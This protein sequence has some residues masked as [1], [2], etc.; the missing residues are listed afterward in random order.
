MMILHPLEGK[1][2][3]GGCPDNDLVRCVSEPTLVHGSPVSGRDQSV[4]AI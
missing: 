3:I 4:E 1:S 2:S